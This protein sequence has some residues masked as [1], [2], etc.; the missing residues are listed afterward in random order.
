MKKTLDYVEEPEGFGRKKQSNSSLMI[1]SGRTMPMN[2]NSQ[3]SLG[4]LNTNASQCVAHLVTNPPTVDY[5]SHPSVKKLNIQCKYLNRKHDNWM[6]EGSTLAKQRATGGLEDLNE[7]SC[8]SMGVPRRTKAEICENLKQL[9]ES[10][11]QNKRVMARYFDLYA[12]V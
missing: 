3:V 11:S 5:S 8:D 7:G 4:K 6:A 10:Q 9:E 2:Q 12:Q 1:K